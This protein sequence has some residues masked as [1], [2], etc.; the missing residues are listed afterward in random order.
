LPLFAD[1][2][3]EIIASSMLT[4]RKSLIF[5]ALASA[6]LLA[7]GFLFLATRPAAPYMPH[8]HCYLW[9]PGL[10]W[11]HVIADI[12]IG[13]AY[14]SIS[15]TLAYIVAKARRDLPF[16]WMF[17]AFGIFIIACGTTH[18]V[19]AWTVWQ[20][21]YWFAAVVKIVTAIAS[22]T[23]AICLPPLVPPIL[24]LLE[25]SRTQAKHR[26]ELEI[27]VQQ[28]LAAEAELLKMQQSLE[29]NVRDRTSKLSQANSALTLYETII[30]NSAGGVAIVDSVRGLIQLANPAFARMHGFE[31]DSMIG[32]QLA[33]TFAPDSL[34]QMPELADIIQAHDHLLY[35]S[36][37]IRKDGSRFNCL[38]DVT[39][40]RDPQGLPL[41]RFGYF[42][43]VTREKRAE[44]DIRNVVKHARCILWR[45]TVEGLNGWQKYIPGECRFGWDL[46]V[47]DEVAAQNFQPLI[48]PEDST[49]SAAWIA[50]RLPDDTM[51][52]DENAANAFIS[53]ADSFTQ[54]FRAYDKF[55][56]IIWVREEIAITRLGPA[57]WQC[58][59]VCMDS[60]DEHRLNDQIRQQA[61]L[62]E[63]SH[64][65]I[66]VRNFEGEIIY[67]NSGAESIYG[68]QRNEAVGQVIYTLLATG[69]PHGEFDRALEERGYWAGQLRHSTKDGREIL[70]DSRHLVV[71]RADGVRLVLET[72]HPIVTEMAEAMLQ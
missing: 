3:I 35:D 20:P 23:T 13:L 22:V 45:A 55:G 17:L 41:Y 27:E 57:K 42:Q 46:H 4:P 10:L 5:T 2:Y 51:R 43:D 54:Q 11:T 50:S 67:W 12:L 18:F 33:K 72:N 8:G 36:V 60:T 70:V 65:A 49:Y 28:R 64:D 62:L 53:G 6:I 24:R 39:L 40:V 47:Q 34:A 61:E 44:E 30:N 66:I 38:T 16:H 14:V 68:W 48:V 9:E 25:S 26:D 7:G 32:M 37:H 59:G 15:C 56:E 69:T 31:P 58:T 63:L 29:Q 1:T 71:R 52:T 21:V 19:E